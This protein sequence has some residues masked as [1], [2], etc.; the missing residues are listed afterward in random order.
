MKYNDIFERGASPQIKKDCKLSD[1]IK[2]DRFVNVD[3]STSIGEKVKIGFHTRIGKNVTI[4]EGV[5]IGDNVVIWDDVAIGKHTR[6]ENNVEIGYANLSK[7]KGYYEDYPTSIGSECIIRSGAIIYLACKIGNNSWIGNYTVIRE[8]TIIGSNTTFGSHIMNEG[9]S[10][11]G[12]NTKV[13]SFCELGGNMFVEDNVFIGPGIITA[14]N[15]KPLMGTKLPTT[16]RWEDGN[17]RVA[18]K[19]PTIR[20]G[21]KIGISATLLA[22]IEIGKGAL[23]AAGSVVTKDVPEFSIALGVPARVKGLVSQ[24]ERFV[25]DS[26]KETN[27]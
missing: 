13:Y 11:F 7:K 17:Q 5:C 10:V 1:S 14:N 3:S 4:E 6:I 25:P 23:V 27:G 15:P 16:S 2:F 18:D 19:G 26:D 8:N 9:Y 21:A 20:E 12:S 24:D 22:E